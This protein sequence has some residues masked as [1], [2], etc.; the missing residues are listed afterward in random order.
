MSCLPNG[1]HGAKNIA[2][3]VIWAWVWILPTQCATCMLGWATLRLL[4]LFRIC[5]HLPYDLHGTGLLCEFLE[6]PSNPLVPLWMA[7]HSRLPSNGHLT[8]DA[9][10]S[11]WCGSGFLPI[12]AP[13]NSLAWLHPSPGPAWLLLMYM[14]CGWRCGSNFCNARFYLC[15]LESLILFLKWD[16][17]FCKMEMILQTLFK[18]FVVG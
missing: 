2:L 9:G 18:T 14:A 13:L 6:K 5:T 12:H 3:G 1:C 17:L 4:V 15:D 8:S 10:S 7:G 16:F 11:S